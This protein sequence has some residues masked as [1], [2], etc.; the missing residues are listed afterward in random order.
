MSKPDHASLLEELRE[1]DRRAT[2]LG[3]P[4]SASRY[5]EELKLIARS[6]MPRLSE[7]MEGDFTDALG[8]WLF[9]RYG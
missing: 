7:Q 2:A 8:Y 5:Q 4:V 3:F 1:A 6:G 9:R